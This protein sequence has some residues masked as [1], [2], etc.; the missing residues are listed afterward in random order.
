M[1][2]VFAAIVAMAIGFGA[3]TWQAGRLGGTAG[4]GSP[5]AIIDTVAVKTDLL[6][7]AGAERQQFALEGK[8]LSLDELRARG[9]K[10]PERRGPYV[11]SADVTDQHFTI[12]AT[13]V[14]TNGEKPQPPM[15]IGPDMQ[16]K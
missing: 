6:S 2:A 13:Y 8:Y 1:R 15:S 16:V 9:V 11:Y 12:T 10:L 3:Y 4:G 7:M 5:T 14:P